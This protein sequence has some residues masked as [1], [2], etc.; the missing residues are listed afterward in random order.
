MNVRSLAIVAATLTVMANTALAVSLQEAMAKAVVTHPEG[1]SAEKNQAAIGHQIDMAKAGYRPTIDLTA[2]TGYEESIN[3]STRF[4]AGR[5]NDANEDDRNLWRNESRLTIRQM[6]WDGRQTQN[7]VSQQTNRFESA[8]Y[9]VADIKNQIA[10]RAAESYLNV[11][12]TKELVA[13]ADA[14]LST[15]KDYVSKI[16]ERSQGGRAPAADVRQAEGRMNLAEAN[17]VA[18]K[19]DL[20]G[21]EADYLEVV[22]EM[23]NAPVKDATP[24]ANVPADTASAIARAASNSPVIAGAQANIKAARAEEAEANCPFC[25]RIEA[26]GGISRNHNLDGVQG[27]NH[28]MTAML[29]LRQNLYNGGHDVAQ[30]AERG[31]RVQEATDDLE[32]QRRLVEQAVI[33]AFAR[34]DTAKGR[35]VPLTQHVEAATATRNAY[36]SQFDLGQRSLLDLLDSEVELTNSRAALINGKYDVDATAYAVLANMGDL[37]P[38]TVVAA[39]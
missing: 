25:P 20:R 6:I 19:G 10:L 24:F 29:Y 12:R 15:H 37:V 5:G 11:L 30:R 7:R 3:P 14:N 33:K 9:N 32:K 34:M 1:L 8:A 18:A 27:V 35:L 36:R 31:A 16:R 28:D 39:K 26:E 2:G 17:L 13:L 4:R 22:G 23:P 38:A 21:A